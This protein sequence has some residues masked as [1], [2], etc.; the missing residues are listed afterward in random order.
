MGEGG[1]R[2]DPE[3]VKRGRLEAFFVPPCLESC[4]IIGKSAL[5]FG[6]LH[7][8]VGDDVR[9]AVTV[10]VH[11]LRKRVCMPP[12]ICPSKRNIHISKIHFQRYLYPDIDAVVLRFGLLVHNG[13]LC[14]ACQLWNRKRCHING[15]RIGRIS[16]A[17]RVFAEKS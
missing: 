12:M 1:A 4:L 11:I 7:L 5:W 6:V 16:V 17:G 10:H 3:P 14:P 15:V 9:I 8:F 2:R 13:H